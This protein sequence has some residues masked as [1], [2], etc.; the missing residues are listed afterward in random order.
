MNQLQELLTLK[1]QQASIVAAKAALDRADQ[2]VKQ[3]DESIQQGKAIMA[4]TI[5]TIIFVSKPC[6]DGIQRRI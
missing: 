6:N 4:F 5:M 2:S 1:Q 3:A